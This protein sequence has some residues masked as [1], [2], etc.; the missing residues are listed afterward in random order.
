MGSLV[1]QI[2]LLETF[3]LFAS[4][5]AL[6]NDLVLVADARFGLRALLRDRQILDLAIFILETPPRA[7]EVGRRNCGTQLWLVH[8]DRNC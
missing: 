6:P 5:L 1:F 3:H 8:Q 7:L 4:T 2:F